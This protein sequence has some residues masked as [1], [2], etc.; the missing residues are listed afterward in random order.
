[1]WADFNDFEL[2]EIA[3]QYG[4]QDHLEF[5]G[6]LRLANRKAIEDLLT[7]YEFDHAFEVVDNNSEVA[8][9]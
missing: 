7:T 9:N 2:A 1:M 8:Y 5:N 3:A 4:F 6:D